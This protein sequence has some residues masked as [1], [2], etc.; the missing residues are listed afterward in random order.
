MIPH[1]RAIDNDA[2][3]L[4]GTHGWSTFGLSGDGSLQDVFN[5]PLDI[6]K[7]DVHFSL[8]CKKPPYSVFKPIEYSF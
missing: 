4:V 2:V 1:I 7:R 3:I 8:L 6:S 5:N